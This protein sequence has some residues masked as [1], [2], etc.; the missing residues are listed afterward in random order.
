M[1]DDEQKEV[2]NEM[3]A[4]RLADTRRRIEEARREQDEW[5]L[6]AQRRGWTQEKMAAAA[7]VT[8]QAV[9]K[10]LKILK[11]RAAHPSTTDE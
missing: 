1:R 5:L 11:V 6:E 9:S 2:S 8:Q 10:R 7:G 3:L 4:E